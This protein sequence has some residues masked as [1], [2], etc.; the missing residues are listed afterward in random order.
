MEIKSLLKYIGV[1][2]VKN[3][4]GDSGLRTLKLAV[5]PEEIIVIN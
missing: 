4:F 3:G 5:S 1:G 2:M